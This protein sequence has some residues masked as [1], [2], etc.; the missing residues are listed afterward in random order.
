MTSP[1]FLL[2]MKSI[3]TPDSQEYDAFWANEK[4][5]ADHGVTVNGVFIDPWLYWHTQLWNIY[6]D[7][8]DPIN[9]SILRKNMKAS[10]RDNEWLIAEGLQDAKLQRKGVMFFGSRRLGKSEFI[11]SYV[12][13]SATLYQGTENVVM[14]GNW[15]DIDVV[16][17]KVSHGLNNLP[18]PFIW[19]RLAENLRKEIE[20]GVKDKKGVRKSWSKIICRNHE[21]G[22]DT[23]SP[24]GLTPSTFIMDEVGKS[25]FAQVF[26][27]AKP[28]FTSKFGWRC[29]PIL[30]GTSGDIKKGG[31]AQKF[32]ENPA[33]NN[34]IVRELLE[35][36]NKKVSVFISGF[37]RMEGKVQTTI[38]DFVK[39]EK[40]ILI[41]DN[42]E[43]YTIPMHV[44]DDEKANAVIDLERKQAAESPDVTALLKA[45]MYY[46]KN[47]K[48][49]FLSDDG[50]N[51]PIE[52]I[53]EQIEYLK[54]NQELQGTPVKLY[55][56]LTTNNIKWSYVT[57]KKPIIDYPIR[58]D[59]P[60]FIKDAS[61][62]MFEPPA[63]DLG[64][65]LYIAGADPYNI[66]NSANS[67]SLGSFYIFKRTYDPIAGTYQRRIVFSYTG[68]PPDIKDFYNNVEM[69]LELYNARCMPENA[70]GNTFI[71][72][73]DHKNKG[74]L[75]ADTYNFLKEISPN[76]SVIN[77][78]K[79]LPATPKVQAYYKELVYLYCTEEVVV[80][81]DPNTGQLLTKLGVHRIQDIGLLR[82]LAAFNKT[83]NFDRYVAFGHTL[84]HE[85]WADK[86]YPFVQA[87]PQPKEEELEGYKKITVRSPFDMTPSN[88]FNLT[89][90]G[91]NP[92][93]LNRK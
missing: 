83:D 14:G 20:L 11:S 26:E 49:L 8:E 1:E 51:F 68:R 13:R 41:P 89:K 39:T 24:A 6:D 79:G 32:F 55:R 30:T 80:G 90:Q 45:T 44:K 43:L 64:S 47:T 53:N 82:E 28:S 70:G 10:F 46:P 25:Q 33:S 38:G 9:N 50:N 81:N 15:G 36:G 35:E 92:F 61:P 40:G 67:S 5:K 52:A 74:Y 59:A 34:F 58:P 73:F 37:Y 48:E 56:D 93:G 87:K 19:P 22:K 75:I 72:H 88:P 23:E 84:A 17:A 2:N 21:E 86:I 62:I 78:P 63:E 69:A 71:Q 66:S 76:T 29:V 54:A 91:S 27:A 65:Y 77:Q 42:S 57:D 4:E 60:S 85:A 3:P 7:V 12:G 31:D 16:M 18:D